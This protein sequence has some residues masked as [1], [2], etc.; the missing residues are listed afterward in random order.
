M[1]TILIVDDHSIIRDGIKAMLKDVKNYMII[2]EANNGKEAILAVERLKPMVVIMDI[3]MP[4]MNGIY[5]TGHLKTN[6]P[7]THVI[8]LT[9]HDQLDLVREMI[10][11][12]VS[13]YLVK[14]STREELILAIDSASKGLSYFSREIT[15][16]LLETESRKNN[17]D[18]VVLT[19][20][21][22]EILKFISEEHTNTQIAEK[23]F[24]SPRTVDSHRR[25]LLEKLGVKNTAGLVRYAIRNGII[26]RD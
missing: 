17:M 9:M 2:G 13:G 14:N 12:G 21:E 5:A 1:I 23:L 10:R 22:K 24:L 8:A 11:A 4:E 6:Y 16:G 15:A 20:R 26:P 25:N 18:S 19:N 7:E 3:S